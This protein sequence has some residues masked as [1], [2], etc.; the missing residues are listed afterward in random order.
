M[1]CDSNKGDFKMA[2]KFSKCSE[3]NEN[4]H[5]GVFQQEESDLF[6]ET[7]VTHPVTVF[8]CLYMLIVC[9]VSDSGS[10]EPLVLD[11]H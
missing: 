11:Y 9:Q 2:A 8:T 7:F 1:E 5:L 4:L 3:I 10:W 6:L